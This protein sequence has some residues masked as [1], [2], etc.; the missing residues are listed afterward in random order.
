MPFRAVLDANVLYPFSLRD[1]LLRLAELELYTPLW[2]DRILDEMTRNLVEHRLTAAQAASIDQ[3]IRLAF[4]EAKIDAGE[5]ERLE[6]AM[7]NEAKD[8]H[9]LAAAVAADSELVV[10]FNLDDFPPEACEPVGVEAVHPDDFLLDLHDL[11]PEAVRAALEQQASDL[12]PAW[13]LEQLLEALA[14]AGVPRFVATV[15]SQT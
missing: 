6:P 1:T 10:T 8:R 12:H 9:V 15:R 3:A 11:A 7:T 5:I 4:D 2:S 14:T 13:P